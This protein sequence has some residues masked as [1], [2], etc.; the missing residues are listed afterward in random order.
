[1]TRRR[2]ALIGFGIALAIIF[3]IAGQFGQGCGSM[4]AKGGFHLTHPRPQNCPRF[5]LF[6]HDLFR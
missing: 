4:N 3:G 1:M 2:W 5:I 6:G